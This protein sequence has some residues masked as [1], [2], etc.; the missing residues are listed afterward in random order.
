MRKNR[1]TDPEIEHEVT[2]A[3]GAINRFTHLVADLDPLEMPLPPRWAT[4]HDAAPVRPNTKHHL[5]VETGHIDDYRRVVWIDSEMSARSMPSRHARRRALNALIKAEAFE[6]FM[7]RRFAG[8]KRFGAEGAESI[9]VLLR[10][11]LDRAAQAGISEVVVGGMHRGRLGL[12]SCV[13]GQPL[14]QMI[15][16]MSGSHP[17]KDAGKA[18]DVPYHLGFEGLYEAPSGPLKVTLLPNPS[19]LEAINAVA[20]GFARR[21]AE[22]AGSGKVLPLLLHTDASVVA[23]GSV[24]ELL[25]LSD[26]SGHSVAGSIHLVVNNQIGFT[27][28][29]HEGRSSRWCTAQFKSID[30]LIAHVNG[31][32][33]DAVVQAAD[34]ALG[35]RQTFGAVAVV[36]L[37]CVRTNGH[38]ELDEPRFT[39]AA[40]YEK[41]GRR[42]SLSDRY[43][44]KLIGDGILDRAEIAEFGESERLRLQSTAQEQAY[45]YDRPQ[46]ATVPRAAPWKAEDIVKLAAD[47][48]NSRVHPKVA[49][50][51][52]Q[53]AS[54]WHEGV[55]WALAEATAL[56][57]VLSTGR[58]VRL[59]GQD[60][61]RGAFSHRHL[62]LI[63]DTGRRWPIFG[64][65]PGTWGRLTVL[66][67]PLSEYAAL[68]F[69]YG[70]SVAAP[71]ALTIWEAQFGDFANGAQIVF[72]QFVSTG[73]EKWQQA[74]NLV[75]LLPHG[76]EGQGPEHSSARIE[77]WLQLA[78]RDN[79]RLTHPSTPANYFHLLVSQTT[80]R[81]PLLVCTPK[82]LLRLKAATSAST[83]FERPGTFQP[84]I[85]TR[86]GD[87][88]SRVILCSG[89]IAYEVEDAIGKPGR[90]D[91][92]VMRLEQLY[93]FPAKEIGQSLSSF[94]DCDIVWL[95]EEPENY[96]AAAWLK[97]RL[98]SLFGRRI[99]VVARPE[100][101]SPPGSFHSNH[102]QDQA[103]LIEIATDLERK[104]T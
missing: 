22:L 77:R 54:E 44:E 18:A 3:E 26:V 11:I 75:I 14:G 97:P 21:R 95:Q 46:P 20:T 7:S 57:A 56:G 72:D 100:N 1:K 89:K 25:Q 84:I 61:E 69:A 90:T 43:A 88:V 92:A 40:Y 27:T 60:V 49:R 102:D 82:K 16:L 38:N 52:A 24:G 67:T 101:P 80:E 30:S 85:M 96:G 29:P 50:L 39:Q 59:T 47:V 13:L 41:V 68:A 55:N 93:P 86:K 51:V 71:D 34:I 45:E 65:A 12:M 32:D 70:Y 66:N 76:L 37:V 79:L 81:R 103:Q 2:E 6:Q 35:Y 87:R 31:D 63:D 104:T 4:L 98:E 91:I 42:R 10:R 53:R 78:A 73:F 36:D 9:H 23:Q 15:A 83:D 28:D 58:D 48:P 94:P 64:R 62:A 19:H 74:S 99:Q 17:F 33:V 5:A 8:K